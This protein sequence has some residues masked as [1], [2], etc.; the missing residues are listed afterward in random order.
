LKRESSR[1]PGRP[2]KTELTARGKT[3]RDKF[4]PV[5]GRRRNVG[6]ET[7]ATPATGDDVEV[8]DSADAVERL[9]EKGLQN[10][11]LTEEEICDALQEYE[12]FD[13]QKFED[14]F[15]LLNDK[16]VEIVSKGIEEEKEDARGTPEKKTRAFREEAPRVEDSVRMYLQ[17][18]GQ[19]RLLTQKEERTLAE[20]VQLGEGTV[21]Y[22]Q[23]HCAIVYKPFRPLRPETLYVLRIEAGEHGV[24]TPSFEPRGRGKHKILGTSPAHD[25]CISFATC[26]RGS[27]LEVVGTS[28]SPG[29][30]APCPPQYGLRVLFNK[31]LDPG[32]ITSR[33]VKVV[34]AEKKRSLTGTQFDCHQKELRIFLNGKLNPDSQ[35]QVVIKGGK[36]GVRDQYGVS[37]GRDYQWS[38][39]T[40]HEGT[41]EASLAVSPREATL[42]AR[43]AEVVTV[44]IPP[45]LP[46]RRV[47]GKTL[48][49]TD[50]EGKRVPGSVAYDRLTHRV[51]FIPNDLFAPRM[52]YDA[53]FHL[54]IPNRHGDKSKLELCKEWSFRTSADNSHPHLVAS[55]P[56]DG[57]MAVGL[58]PT[59]VVYFS[60][61][62]D[63]SSVN[64]EVV[65][66]K[67]EEAIKRLAE[68]NLRLVVSIAKKY[69]GRSSLTFLD[70][71][72]EGNVGLMR[73]VEKFD[74]R[75]GFRFSTYATWWI[76]Q[77]IT[78]AIADQGR[79]IRLPV[80]MV[81]TMNRI[82]RAS[83]EL[84]QQL[85]REPTP[86]EVARHLQIPPERMVEI[87]RIAP[88]PLSLDTPV[89]GRDDESTNLADF[90]E[91]KTI[92][93][94]L[95][96]AARGVLREELSGI[97]DTLPERERLI[98]EHRFGLVDGQQKTLE[99]VGHMFSVTRERI[100][101][102]EAKALKKLRHPTRKRRLRRF[103]E[104]E[105]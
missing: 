71:I 29:E 62:L 28:P 60:Q 45:Y 17:T 20:R 73:A 7:G 56:T 13:E 31:P 66:L 1:R 57:E 72:Q 88:E 90:I 99:E 96:A 59:I 69:T 70:L 25:I 16:G 87:S 64:Q 80:H 92:G 100:R 14:V 37:L 46:V 104:F 54:A 38:F 51:I 53:V 11:E 27:A 2:R 81:E 35:Y 8:L 34:D 84:L 93:S 10:G 48:T 41:A 15:Q 97:L 5:A 98:I 89:P 24:R 63:P 23:A 83:R 65:K 32:S 18:I 102:I 26:S 49:V 19:I 52:K 22:D 94:P 82:A 79:V 4:D 44:R 3:K 101:Q 36:A 6:V 103:L 95:D 105:D 39:A 58:E 91:D 55:F 21:E 76:R 74:F 40:V 33:T 77:A 78:R 68:A 43:I 61:R 86:D 75:K 47:S 30:K 67:D 9:L 50:E 12:D 85:G 42:S